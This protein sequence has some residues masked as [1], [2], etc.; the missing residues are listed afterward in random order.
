MDDGAHA[1]RELTAAAHWQ[2]PA[3]A[4]FQPA[5]FSPPAVTLHAAI[6]TLALGG[7]ERIVLDWAV[8]AAANHRVRLNVLR[9]APAEWPMPPG[10][11][12]VRMRVDVPLA[13]QLEHEGRII[14]ASGNCRIL[15]H[16]LKTDERA[17]L[18]RGGAAPVI[19]VHNARAGWIE[20]DTH[21]A[22]AAEIIAV[23]EA[24]ANELRAVGA[25]A[26]VLRHFPRT[27]SSQPDARSI[28]RMRWDVPVHA[29]CIG[30][31][32]GIKPQK[33]YPR[34][35][36][37]LSALRARRD[38]YLVILGGPTGRDGLL[39]W[40]AAVTQA[41]RLGVA[42]FVRLP[43]F[44][45]SAA[46]ALPA[47]DLLLNTSRYEGV[48]V[49][50]MEALAAGVPVVASSVGGQ[51]EVPAL[52][53][54]LL[55]HDAAVS[56]WVDVIDAALDRRHEPPLWRGF[57]S[58]RLWTLFHIDLPKH[59]GNRTVFVTANLNAGGAQRSLVNLAKRLHVRVAL[60]I[61]VCGVSTAGDFNA[62]LEACGVATYR[63]AQGRDCF[64]HAEALLLRIARGDVGR[65]VFWNADPKVKLLL[66]KRLAGSPIA[67]I[68]VSPGAY[69]FEEM[70]ATV[71]FQTC[72]A[73]RSCDYYRWLHRLVLKYGAASPV[74]AA[75]AIIPNGVPLPRDVKQFDRAP[76][77]VV[78]SGRIAPSKFLLEIVAAMRLVW[79]VVPDA[80]LHILG[81][82]EP[83]HREYSEQ[84][85]GAIGDELGRRAFAHG[86]AFDAPDRLT[87]FDIALVL[88]RHQGS[89][90]AVLE[91]MAAGLVVVANDSGGTRE[92]VTDGRTG[93]LLDSR[94][95]PEMAQDLV[96]LM[97][98]LRLT[99]RLA[100]AGHKYVRR[101]YSM[102]RM[103]AAYEKLLAG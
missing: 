102:T 38:A 59:A 51:A 60:E 48:S 35:I 45:A 70:D 22:G 46:H 88:G 89:P 20:S 73:H 62:E 16:L 17:A 5:L 19:V 37:I 93:L 82:A 61:A 56:H 74:D 67:V 53:L 86:A 9:S 41:E 33:A 21:H 87:E 84:V 49:A 28:W 4:A 78:V 14:S 79:A 80:E 47:F 50:T 7:A 42:D 52:G 101:R 63:T 39:A 29:T 94:E 69:A 57:P 85:L 55:P 76:R 3:T 30:M 54:A 36:A 58:V 43:G 11:E 68:D 103:V 90:N 34:A 66:S 8:A 72:I 32:G 27:P 92:L 83:R 15:C 98:D 31:I 64:D 2:A 44:V 96:R 40:H 26:V 18:G 91:A 13:A 10:I 100:R 95:P 99:K 1:A 6:A 97:I 12:V 24:A 81:T 25:N 65:I 71:G 77:K 23:S 75:T